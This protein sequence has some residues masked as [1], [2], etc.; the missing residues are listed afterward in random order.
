MGRNMVFQ[1]VDLGGSKLTCQTLLLVDQCSPDFDRRMWEESL[2]NIIFP[3]VNISI[4]SRDIRGGN[5][6]LSEITLNLARFWFPDLFWGKAPNFET[7]I[8][9]RNIFQITW[10][11]F[12]SVGR[13]SQ[14]ISRWRKRKERKEASAV[15]HKTAGNYRSGRPNYFLTYSVRLKDNCSMCTLVVNT[16]FHR[17]LR[18]LQHINDV[19]DHAHAL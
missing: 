17:T 4:R 10:Q 3:T 19:H 14:E 9:K 11:S 1:K 12:T 6:K 2:S 15:K 16:P 13:G 7:W 5:L 8:K 18:R